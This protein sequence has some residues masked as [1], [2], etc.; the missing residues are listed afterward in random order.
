MTQSFGGAGL[1][2]CLSMLCWPGVGTRWR[3][4][5]EFLLQPGGEEARA[6]SSRSAFEA[7][8]RSLGRVR[9]YR[10]LALDDAA[11]RKILAED[12]IFPSGRLRGASA[13]AL[14]D[15]ID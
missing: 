3:Q 9:T 2:D 6:R 8:A 4:C 15:I 14:S 1:T 7:F 5:L 10:A 12:E 13:E 11:Y